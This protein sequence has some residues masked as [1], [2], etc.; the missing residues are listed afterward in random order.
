MANAGSSLGGRARLPAVSLPVGPTAHS[1]VARQT[2]SGITGTSAAFAIE[3]DCAPPTLQ[4]AAPTCGG[5]VDARDDLATAPGVQAEVRVSSPNQPQVDVTLTLARASGSSTVQTS[6]A[7]M[8]SPGATVHVLGAMDFGTN[9]LA[10][11][12]ASALDGF[13][14]ATVTPVCNVTV[15]RSP[16]L[17]LTPF[18]VTT[19]DASNRA[20]FDCRPSTPQLDLTV[21]GT[22]T[23]SSGSLVTVQVGSAAPALATVTSGAF[24]ACL[25]APNGASSIEASVTDTNGLDGVSGTASAAPLGITVVGVGY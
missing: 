22:T 25:P 3:A 21:A 16:S 19:F 20:A 18:A 1:L 9:G 4:I 8:L 15:A 2:V 14:N 5:W 13:G 11:L 23:A 6:F 17:T 10:R 12:V 24:S 7:S